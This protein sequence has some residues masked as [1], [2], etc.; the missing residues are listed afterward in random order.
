MRRTLLEMVAAVA[1]MILVVLITLDADA[2]SPPLLALGLILLGLPAALTA[3]RRMVAAPDRPPRTLEERQIGL[4]RE[5]YARDALTEAQLDESLAWVLA[6]NRVGGDG[7][8]VGDSEPWP[9]AGSSYLPTYGGG[10][11]IVPEGIELST[12]SIPRMIRVIG[13]STNHLQVFGSTFERATAAARF[14]SDEMRRQMTEPIVDAGPSTTVQIVQAV[15]DGT[16]HLRD[17][18]M[19]DDTSEDLEAHWWNDRCDRCGIAH[20]PTPPTDAGLRS[21]R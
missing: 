9:R 13:G 7:Q 12:D 4:V 21:R 1:G 2:P 11:L 14:Y 6:G 20:R 15:E 17:V 19:I 5:A 18:N 3:T 8:P 16:Y 10:L